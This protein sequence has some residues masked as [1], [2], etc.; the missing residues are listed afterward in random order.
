MEEDDNGDY[1]VMPRP[2]PPREFF[3]TRK[4]MNNQAK[5]RRYRKKKRPRNRM[6]LKKL[7]EMKMRK[8]KEKEKPK[9]GP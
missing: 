9:V 8:M 7:K 5:R 2:L 6:R 4:Q 3:K 1:A